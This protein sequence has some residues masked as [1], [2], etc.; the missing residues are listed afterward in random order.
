MGKE[1]PLKNHI[2]SNLQSI[3]HQMPEFRDTETNKR[4]YICSD[5]EN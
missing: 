2:L 4:F 3:F 5:A 1:A